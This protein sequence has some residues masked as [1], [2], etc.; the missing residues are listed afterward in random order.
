MKQRNSLR[1]EKL[2]SILKEARL[3]AGLKQLELAA[4]LKR[5]DSY[6][7]DIELGHR[8]LDVLEFIDYADALGADPRKLLAKLM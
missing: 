3:K 2:R 6:I 8:M 7:S 4:R 1:H 5:S